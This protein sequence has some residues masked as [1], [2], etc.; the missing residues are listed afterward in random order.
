MTTPFDLSFPSGTS[1]HKSLADR[2]P[3]K[4]VFLAKSRWIDRLERLRFRCIPYDTDIIAV[5][6][7][8]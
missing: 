6:V 2:G 3:V 8:F 7:K 5:N 1:L 4:A